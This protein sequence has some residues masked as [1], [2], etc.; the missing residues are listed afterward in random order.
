[1]LILIDEC[2]P[3][4]FKSCLTN[5]DVKTVYDMGWPGMKNGELIKQKILR[6][7]DDL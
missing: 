3:K 1:M 7:I 5:H 4:K 2:I 6:I